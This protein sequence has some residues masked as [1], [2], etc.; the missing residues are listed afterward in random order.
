MVFLSVGVGPIVNRISRLMM[1]RALRLADYR[2]YR[3]KFAI[4]Y[5]NSVGFDSAGDPVFPD[6]VFGL[7][8]SHTNQPPPTLNG[9]KT[10]GLGVINYYGWRHDPGAG[11]AIYQA[12]LSKIKGF[13]SWLLEKGYRIRLLVGDST[14]V[15]PL[16][17]ILAFARK[18]GKSRTAD[19][20][21]V[22]EIATVKDLL[23]QISQTD[24]IVASRFHN[25]V[26]ALMLL[27]PV[28]SLGYHDKNEELMTD[29]GLQILC[30]HIEDFTLKKL[31]EQFEYCEKESDQIKV[32]IQSR[33][34]KYRQLLEIQYRDILS[35]WMQN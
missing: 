4:K 15:Q 17:E 1:L 10:V 9:L 34:D 11:G 12:Y 5:L 33:L 2:S 31:I 25:V 29:I 7:P 13:V 21:L 26:C 35:P 23:N 20:I 14:D 30:Q 28:V 3:E 8:E 32:Q 22:E 24:Y 18:A 19:Q 16:N 6:L 27:K